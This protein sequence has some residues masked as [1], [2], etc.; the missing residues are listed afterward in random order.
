M[1]ITQIIIII[2]LT[3]VT[4]IIV[5][6]GIWLITILKELKNT[7]SKT[8]EILDDAKSITSC[9]V[10]PVCTISDFIQGF[11]SGFDLLSSFFKKKDGKEE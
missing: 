1:D 8:N 3:A 6:C 9:V 7:L 5:F 11:K 10:K 4:T 2:S